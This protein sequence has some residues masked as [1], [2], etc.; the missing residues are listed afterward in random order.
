M[1]W[2][3][4]GVDK[5]GGGRG[6]ARGVGRGGSRGGG[7][8]GAKGGSKVIIEPHRHEGKKVLIDFWQIMA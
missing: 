7:R 1:L 8:G 6:G 3:Q 4:L 5:R 2:L